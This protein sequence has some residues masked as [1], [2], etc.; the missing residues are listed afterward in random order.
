MIVRIEAN[1]PEK[2]Q[3]ILNA[4]R[5]LGV[6]VLVDSGNPEEE[7]LFMLSRLSKKLDNLG[8]LRHLNKITG[9]TREIAERATNGSAYIARRHDFETQRNIAYLKAANARRIKN[10]YKPVT[11]PE[12]LDVMTTA[13]I[14]QYILEHWDDPT[15]ETA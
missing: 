10:G 15:L 5:E 14:D 11:A 12:F 13:E 2:V 6:D 8:Q 1:E 7:L 4:V 9:Y 3:S